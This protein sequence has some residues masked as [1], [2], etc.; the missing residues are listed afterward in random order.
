MQ[1]AKPTEPP[2]PKATVFFRSLGCPKN[3]VD[4]EIMLGALAVGHYAIAERLEDADLAVV[5]T[6]SFIES[7]REESIATILELADLKEEGGLKALVVTGCLPQRYGRELVKELPEVDAFVG[8]GDFPRIAEIL[9]RALQGGERGI[10]V[11][12]GR[13]H[14]YDA[15]QPRLLIG[16]QHSAYVKIAEGCDRVCAFCAIPGIRGA[17]Q[18]RPIES[19]IQEAVALG[20]AG[21]VELN[22]VSQDT[23]SY[24]KDLYGRPRLADL[25]RSIDEVAEI[26]WVRLLYL[27]PSAVSDDLIDAIAGAR[28]VLPYIDMPLQ[29]ASDRL[30]RSM[31]R[32]VT[33]VRQRDRV[34]RIRERIADVVLRTTFI[35]G[36]PGETDED[37][38]ILCDF[39]REMRFDR[40]G[41]FRYSDEEKTSAAD[42]AEKVPRELA[43]ERYERL[44]S[45]QR[46]LMTESLEEFVGNEVSVLIDKSVAGLGVGRLWSQAPEIDGVVFVRGDVTAGSFVR[47]RVTGVRNADLE[48]VPLS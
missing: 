10:Y 40:V 29:H 33:A 34:A 27:Y 24:G 21:T 47:A 42:Y 44:V 19:V 9:D 13:T 5:N 38:E 32:G 16:G 46:E 25:V 11:D 23:T 14:L 4:T 35:V 41:A 2:A 39:V 43:L 8:T 37:F 20:R 30:L 12:A 1:P 45:L 48:A 7:A 22:L 3:Q 36:F 31:K 17:F 26:E 18:S 28:R 15:D 6:C